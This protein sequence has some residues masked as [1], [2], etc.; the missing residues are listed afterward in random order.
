M[1][2]TTAVL[3]AY[4]LLAVLVTVKSGSVDEH[5]HR[6]RSITRENGGAP[7]REKNPQFWNNM[8]KNSI[9]DALR[10]QRSHNMKIAKNVVMFLGDGMGVVTVTSARILKGQNAGNPGEETVLTMDTLPHVALS[11]TYNIDAQ[12]PDSAATATAYLCGVKAAYATVGVDGRA[13]NKDCSSSKGAE[14]QSILA[15]AESAGKSTG[16]VT[17]ARMTHAT[18]AATYA[19]SASREWEADRDLSPEAVQND[20]KDIATQLVDDNPGI[21]VLLGGGR[22]NFHTGTDPEYPDDP[23]SNGV[24]SDGRNLV[25]DWLVGKTSARYVWNGTDFRTV[26]PQ[27]TDYLL[28]LF[29][30]SHMKYMTDRDDSPSEEPT[31]AEMT[32]T[33]IQILQKNRNGFFLLVEG[34]RIDHGHHDG[35]AVKALTEAVAFDDA[36]KV[37]KDMLNLEETLIIVTADHGHT[38]SFGGWDTARGSPVFGKLDPDYFVESEG[39]NLVP[40]GKPYT[41]IQYG[42]GPGYNISAP[43][44]DITNVD[45]A[46]PDY[47][48]QS[49]VPTVVESH[50][51][52]DVAIF[53]DGPMAHLFH[54]V[55]EQNYIA[56]VMKYAACLGE[57]AEDCDREERVASGTARGSFS[58]AAVL[59]SIFLQLVWWL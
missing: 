46:H 52:E 53:A 40:D 18:P 38:V 50:G 36:I 45:T 39:V 32:R 55:H 17:T 58:T 14:V 26:N 16:V 1:A 35:K 13:W 23:G 28:G 25:Q 31:L 11:K 42:T 56:H 8:A 57:Y 43:R 3:V 12:T 20:C 29:E 6:A 9:Q 10:I 48:Q 30:P 2:G 19:H 59:S 44:E 5:A 47:L 54:G 34:G 15:L 33:A 4:S 49:A 37:G 51:A 7:E 41:A 21:E 22:R 24:R 27:T